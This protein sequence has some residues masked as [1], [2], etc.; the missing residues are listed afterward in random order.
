MTSRWGKLDTV[1]LG[2]CKEPTNIQVS[3]THKFTTIL[4]KKLA[5]HKRASLFSPK[6]S[7][8]D[9]KVYNIDTSTTPMYKMMLK[10]I[11]SGT[12]IFF[13]CYK[14]P[15]RPRGSPGV[16]V[17]LKKCAPHPTQSKI[18]L[19]YMFSSS[20]DATTFPI[21]TQSRMTL[22]KMTYNRV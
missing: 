17:E 14:T 4:K 9:K 7:D 10:E 1:V 13:I 20:S 3:Y 15:I 22:G 12:F 18:V 16:R 8:E 6:A 11:R 5:R 2:I 19:V 21:M